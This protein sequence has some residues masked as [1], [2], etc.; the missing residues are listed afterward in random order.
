VANS[1][2]NRLLDVNRMAEHVMDFYSIML[3][4]RPSDNVPRNL[5]EEQM[6]AL[7]TMQH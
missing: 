3:V 1:A 5:S 2:L 4:T 7:V 6:L